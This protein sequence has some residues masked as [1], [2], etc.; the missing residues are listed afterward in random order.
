MAK[1]FVS[2][3]RKDKEKVLSVVNRIQK[4]LN[5]ECWMDI[6]G[7]ESNAQFVSVII[8]AIDE[9]E[10]ILFMYSKSHKSIQNYENDW[11]IRELNYAQERN[12]RIVFVNI[13]GSELI[14]WFVFMFPKKQQVNAQSNEEIAKLIKDIGHWL[15]IDKKPSSTNAF[16]SNSRKDTEIANDLYRMG[17]MLCHGEGT[18]HNYKEAI[19]WYKKAA[20]LGHPEAMNALGLMYEYSWGVLHNDVEAVRYYQKAADGNHADALFNLGRMFEN[21]QGLLDRDYTKA[22]ECYHKASMMGNAEAQNQL[23]WLYHIGLGVQQDYKESVKWITAS[24]NQGLVLAQNNLGWIYLYGIGAPKNKEEAIKWFM[25]A[26]KQGSG[27]ACSNLR[28]L[29]VDLTPIKENK[30]IRRIT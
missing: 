23:G 10:I 26:A 14:S 9:A 18:K 15:K 27:Y 30:T 29:G 17:W 8:R 6:S 21:G 3:K 19:S 4:E 13:D 2:Y 1:I 16:V 20:E 12:K 22:V 11:T 28:D 25:K 5:V 7:I 24:A